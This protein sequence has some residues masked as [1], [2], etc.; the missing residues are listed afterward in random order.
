[1]NTLIEVLQNGIDNSTK[2]ELLELIHEYFPEASDL[3]GK[4]DL[5]YGK[6]VF[7]LSSIKEADLFTLVLVKRLIRKRHDP[8]TPEELSEIDEAFNGFV[9]R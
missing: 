3:F 6:E 4:R 5:L 8:L 2:E 1:M 9:Y 7:K